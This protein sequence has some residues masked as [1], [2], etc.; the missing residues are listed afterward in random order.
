MSDTSEL[1]YGVLSVLAVDPRSPTEAHPPR[2]RTLL[3]L[4][5]M[6][7]VIGGI[8]VLGVLD[9]RSMSRRTQEDIVREQRILAEV[10]AA[11]FKAGIAGIDAGATVAG[12]ATV[13]GPL[14]RFAGQA[15]P[16]EPQAFLHG[17]TFAEGGEHQLLL[18]STL[19][20]QLRTPQGVPA[21]LP[22][23]AAAA[24]AGQAQAWLE[25]EEAASLGLPNEVA[26]AG[27]AHVYTRRLGRWAIV[28]VS[29]TTRQHEGEV[30]RSIR[31]VLVVGLV[32]L[33][34][35]GF[36]SLLLWG[37]RQERALERAL[38]REAL[39]S[40]QEAQLEREGR[41]ATMMTFAAGMAH[42][43]STPLGVIA[44]R[45]EQLEN[46]AED[47]RGRR[48]ARAIGEQVSRIR[49]QAQRF[50]AIARGAAPLRQRFPADEVL[51]RAV[52]LVQHRF[53]RAGVTLQ[54]VPHPELPWIRGDARL[55]EHALTNLLLNACD[56]SRSGGCV[57]LTAA[58]DGVSVTIVVHDDGVGIDPTLIQRIRPF[59]STKAEGEGTGL[60]LAIASE[61]MQMHR[62]E[63]LLEAP[64]GG[65]TRAVLRLPA[66]PLDAPRKP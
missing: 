66:E 56:A 26:V 41:A 24:M 14:W 13:E 23:V 30:R 35:I 17:H 52:A 6:V 28:V 21:V 2:R 5:A 22:G 11:E 47:D 43:I 4:L 39:R 9:E 10:L 34:V 3:L 58:S 61:V 33:V 53:D 8:A 31:T 1:A 37:Q 18:W 57:D 65:G 48:G 12:P 7:L 19:A 44:M 15:A 16:L 38:V 63:L 32:S 50:L 42:E 60:G 55:L 20:P 64:A 40:E 25:P 29:S 51:Q 49:E 62:G 36:G 46:A 45:A 54:V 27:L 59:F